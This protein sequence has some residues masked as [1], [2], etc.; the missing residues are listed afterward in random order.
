MPFSVQVHGFSEI[1]GEWAELLPE[2]TTNTIFVT[3]WWQAAWWQRF[4]TGAELCIASVRNGGSVLGI[5]PLVLRD[6]VV[7]FLGDTDL[8]DY[9]DF[10]VPRG[11]E[12]AF[13]PALCEFLLS[14]DWHTLELKSVPEDSPTLRY[15]P[16]LAGRK[17]FA[18]ELKEE[19]RAPIAVLPSTWE[20]YLERLSKKD[21]HEL[22]RKLRRLEKASGS[23]QYVCTMPDVVAASMQEFF[24][25]LRAS[26]PNKQEFLTPEREG[27]FRD[28]AAELARRGQF[29]LYFLEVE[30]VRVAAC[31]CFDHADSYLLYNSGY[32]PSY[33]ALSV[34]LLNK[35][36]CLKEA[37][38]EGR[39]YFDFLRGT[40]RYKYDLGGTDRVIYRLTVRR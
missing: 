6:G 33:S 11:K 5:A 20:E 1:Q 34:G 29:R 22:R 2:C 8:F 37:I 28:V 36:L 4:G 31:I 10:I 18:V 9:H 27:F 32:D 25:L 26:D 40:E 7:S 19:D 30:G 13:Y 21:R 3:P 17:G 12:D 14:L 15:V 38:E 39:K 35:A 24:H 23:R 16:A